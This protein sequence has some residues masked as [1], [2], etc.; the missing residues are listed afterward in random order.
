VRDSAVVR[1]PGSTS[2]LGAGFDCVG[3]AVDRWLTVSVSID[4][5]PRRRVVV[6][7]SGTLTG[8]DVEPDDDYI[9]AG[10]RAACR[11]VGHP[12][13][14]A[15][16]IRAESD[17]PVGRG[18]GSSGA[19]FVAGAAAANALLDFGLDDRA[20]V[21]IGSA[22]EG[23][24]DN[25]AP[26]VYGGAVLAVEPGDERASDPVVAPLAIHP[27]L[28]FVFAVPDFAVETKHARRVLPAALPHRVA[29][30]AVARGAALLQGL[31]TA[32][33]TLLALG[34]DDVLH[35][36]FRRALVPGY[37]AVTRAALHAG[38]HGAT[39]SGSGSSILAIAPA[40]RSASV[41][42]AMGAAWAALGIR[43][44]CFTNTARVPGYSG[45]LD[46]SLSV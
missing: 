21:G 1:V 32:N 17:I 16:H 30:R 27:S 3:V 11:S 46:A 15:L 31:A 18:L 34:L 41:S 14:P 33:P 26:A 4:Y 6:E 19:A 23:H 8:L 39:L 38:A 40:S 22:L 7:R 42:A 20:L 45:A 44:T 35:V 43:A 28:H 10:F 5:D 9:A 24:P 2:N 29:T 25:V 37:E 12:V 13:P 36:P